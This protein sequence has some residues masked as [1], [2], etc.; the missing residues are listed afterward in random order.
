[1]RAVRSLALLAALTAACDQSRTIGSRWVRDQQV[2][3]AAGAA[4]EV[5]AAE[6]PTLA[7]AALK[8]EPGALIAD[9]DI[10]VEVGPTLP[11]EPRAAGPAVLWGPAGLKLAH[12]ALMSLP[13][14]L[15]AGQLPDDLIV[16]TQDP[17]GRLARIDHGSLSLDAAN[18]RVTF[19]VEH[20]GLFQPAAIVRC[21]ED[22]ECG[23]H[24]S[25]TSGECH[26]DK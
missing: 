7:G 23:P 5:T 3:A 11:G 19:L 21:H 15:V 12:P 10:T 2:R 18:R 16:I 4:I 1:M 13:V 24:E 17:L 8:L 26:A 20:L 22:A 9:T 14:V 6:D 25:C